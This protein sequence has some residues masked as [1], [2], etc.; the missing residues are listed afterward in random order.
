MSP[1]NDITKAGVKL[2]IVDG[3]DEQLFFDAALRDHLG[4]ALLNNRPPKKD[5]PSHPRIFSSL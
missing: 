1:I 5:Y 4:L 3:R 2:L